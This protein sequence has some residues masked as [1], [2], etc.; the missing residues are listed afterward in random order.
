MKREKQPKINSLLQDTSFTNWAKES[1][2]SD[3]AFWNHWIKQHP[4]H[5]DMIYTAKAMVLGVT[6]NKKIV[7]TSLVNSE[8]DTVLG[9]INAGDKEVKARKFFTL[10]KI[11]QRY[12]AI[13][14][15]L[16]LFVFVGNAVLNQSNEVIHKTAFGEIINLRLPD[17]TKVVLNGNS[18][19]RYT[20]N[21]PR[22][23]NL[24]GEAY[25]KVKPILETNAK[26]W[27][28]T[29]DLTVEVY[30]TEFNVNSRDE[31]TNVLLDEGSIHLLLNNGESKEMR[32]GEFVSYSEK[33]KEITH[34]K[35]NSDLTYS[36]WKEG[37][38]IFN[39]IKLS[40]VM[41]Y[42]ENTYGVSSKFQDSTLKNQTISG[43][44]PNENLDIC[45]NAIQ[46]STG[47]TISRK[48]NKLLIINST[49]NQ[50]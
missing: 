29:N 20:K 49:I 36:T 25:F 22:N 18:E 45:L 35:I 23:I 1:N 41:K 13:A 8:L 40:E 34:E 37:T 44:I 10:N 14:A 27:V 28:N 4:E 5:V 2:K 16:I 48:N 17:G 50:N 6:F 9:R 32:P 46:K 33:K 19:I 24:D 15:V 21:N 7:Q 12:A 42:V 39:N 3:I 38:F 30:G 31:K 43:G 47:V 26:F 11:A